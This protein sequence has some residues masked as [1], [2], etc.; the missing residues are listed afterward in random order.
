MRQVCFFCVGGILYP[1]IELLW[2]GRTHC[3]MAVAGGISLCCIDRISRKKRSLFLQGILCSALITAVEFLFG[4][5]VNRIGHRKVWDYSHLPG[6]L[7]GQICLPFSIAW[8]FLSIPAI[9]FCR[10]CKKKNI[11]KQLPSKKQQLF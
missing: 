4:M 11:K 3:S 9:G 10:L 7:F 5:A 2:R 6:N 8:F 1:I